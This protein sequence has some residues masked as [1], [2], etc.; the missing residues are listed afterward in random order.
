MEDSKG[1]LPFCR[2][3]ED[4]ERRVLVGTSRYSIP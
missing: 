2:L 4:I 1:S 3:E